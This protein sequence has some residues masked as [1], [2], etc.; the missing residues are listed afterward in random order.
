M[1]LLTSYLHKSRC[2]QTVATVIL[3]TTYLW[4]PYVYNPLNPSGI[5][6]PVKLYEYILTNVFKYQLL[7]SHCDKP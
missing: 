3:I 4:L 2:H 5:D 7:S 6:A 1:I